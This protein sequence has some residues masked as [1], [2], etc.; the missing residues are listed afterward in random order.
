MKKLK[1]G[2][3]TCRQFPPSSTMLAIQASV[4]SR[5]CEMAFPRATKTEYKG[6]VYRSK[7][8]AMF[9][10]YL[11]LSIE[12]CVSLADHGGP[13]FVENAMGHDIG[14][15]I[16]EPKGFCID[17]WTPDFISWQT[18]CSSHPRILSGF[19]IPINS[20]QVIEY[21][22]SKPTLTYV[23]KFMRRAELLHDLTLAICPE[24]TCR[25]SF[26]L[27]YGSVYTERSGKF[28][29]ESGL[30]G[31]DDSDRYDWIANYA[32]AI[33]ETRFDLESAR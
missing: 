24:F 33:L 20:Y 23:E 16:Y 15:F 29:A 28:D 25:C 3:L 27:Y 4:V 6:I 10:R 18:N 12:D 17:G 14:G 19:Q 26:E 7:C 5:G 21:K 22:P 11:E 1:P 8:E 32:E 31:F 2:S 9:A 30:D 13:F